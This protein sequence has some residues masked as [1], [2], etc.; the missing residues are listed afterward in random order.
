MEIILV[1]GHSGAGKS[2]LMELM[3]EGYKKKGVKTCF[4]D[5][6]ETIADFRYA[7]RCF[8]SDLA[9]EGVLVMS[10]LD[11]FNKIEGNLGITRHIHV[12]R[13]PIKF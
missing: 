5:N 4:V 3:L 8:Q 9:G 10:S 6:I 7:V 12:S 1:T 13:G 11:I 2:Y